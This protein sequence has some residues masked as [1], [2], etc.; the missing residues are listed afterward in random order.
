MKTIQVRWTRHAGYCW[1]SRNK[2][3]SDVLL[4]IPNMAGQKPDDQHKHTFSSYVKIR[5]VALKTCLSWWTIGKS[6][7]RWSVIS[8]L[9]AWHDDDYD[10]DG[11]KC[12]TSVVLGYSEVTLLMQRDDASLCLLFSGYIWCCSIRAVC[13]QISLFPIDLGLYYLL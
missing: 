10:D 1:R 8:V 4:W 2:L 6:G 3:I 5:D 9:V 11:S 7:E 13:C 12:S